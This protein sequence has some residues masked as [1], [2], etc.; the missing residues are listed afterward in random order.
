MSMGDG[1]MERWTGWEM[2]D[3]AR[4]TTPEPRLAASLP[5]LHCP[6]S[7]INEC[8]TAFFVHPRS[9]LLT[10]HARNA[11]CTALH[12]LHVDLHGQPVLPPPGRLVVVWRWLAAFAFVGAG[13]QRVRPNH[14]VGA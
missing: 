3:K 4:P 13:A 14:T 11:Q 5:R 8:A 7:T 12:V 9:S 2:R 10:T 1:A 6:L